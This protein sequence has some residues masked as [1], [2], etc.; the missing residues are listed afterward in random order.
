[1][2]SGI[3][4]VISPSSL[5]RSLRIELLPRKIVVTAVC[6]YWIKDTEFIDVATTGDKG[7]RHYPFASDVTTVG[8]ISCFWITAG[9]PVVTTCIISTIH[10]FFSKLLP[11]TVLQYIWG[12]IRRL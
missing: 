10:R 11:D 5:A 12:G 7:L 2:H 9:M 4:P 6:P 1:M 8:R 3:F